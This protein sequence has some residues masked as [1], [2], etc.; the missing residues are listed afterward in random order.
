MPETAEGPESL[1]QSLTTAWDVLMSCVVVQRKQKR[2]KW[3]SLKKGNSIIQ[4]LS[5]GNW[6]TAQAKRTSAL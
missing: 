3:G 1:C 5:T 4:T 6:D 2:A